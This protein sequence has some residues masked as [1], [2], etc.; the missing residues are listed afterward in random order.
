[1]SVD[2]AEPARGAPLLRM[3]KIERTFQMGEVSVEVLKK[4]SLEIRDGE[5]LAIV[6]PSG[7]GKTTILNLIGG[8]D[9][10]TG[11][12]I[13]FRQRDMTHASPSELTGYRREEIGFVFQ[14][15]NLVPNLTAR[16]NVMVATELVAQPRDVDEVLELVGL[17]D[18]SEHF[19]A[20]LSGGEQQR[21]AIARAVA[22]SPTL[23][24]C[25]EPTGSLDF[26]TG[27]RVLRLLVDLNRQ[28]K[29][30]VVI[31]THNGAI[32]EVADRVVH[33]RSGEITEVV[34]ER[35]T[36]CARGGGL[37][38][39][40][41]RKLLR[42]LYRAKGLLLAITSIV[43]V[44]M[45][46]FVSMR[47]AYHNLQQAKIAYYRQCR[48]ADFWIDLKK[49]PLAEIAQLEQ[50]PGV[51]QI[52]P[53]IQFAATVDL[54][55]VAKPINSLVLSLPD[56][57][58]RV[59][60]DIVLKQG[61]YFTD[62]R[63]NEVIVNASFARHHNL[64][65]GSWIH[66]LLNNRRQEL[67]VVGTAISSEFTYLLGPGALVPDP[68]S[69]GVFYLKQSYAEEVFDFD[70][71]ANQV[72]GCLAPQHAQTRGRRCWTEAEQQLDDFG[73]FS[74]TPRQFQ[75]S[76]QFLEGE[77]A[78]LG[79]TAA[80]MP[81]IFLIV[82]ALVLNVLIT[83]LTRQQRTVIGTLKALGYTDWQVFLHF[84]KFGLSVGVVGGLLGSVLGYLSATGMTVMYRQFFEFP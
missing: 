60:N 14:F 17:E 67:F 72:V 31:I 16:E 61:D 66:L 9:S 24:L 78:G 5:F 52:T 75:V 80:V 84:L 77:I 68:S 56:D 63:Q 11:G 65:P 82:A 81:A 12:Q 8:L 62:R 26:Q 23:L 35:V 33:L 22:K 10:P 54:E 53:R 4:I 25:D 64:Y 79:A 44:G 73:V 30:T 34:A 76:N 1:M 27:K 32:A 3:E 40:L 7:S 49:A 39:M 71:A 50:I 47:S 19:P 51:T 29:T 6:G 59:V 2:S 58:Q 21:V 28:W 83:R 57:R 38:S 42:E 15:F 20:Q 18:R 46:C 43:A 69:F 37:V 13:Y 74:T 70:G 45:T 36:D 41:D 55:H 48:M